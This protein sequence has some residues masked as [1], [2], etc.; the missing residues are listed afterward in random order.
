MVISEA[1]TA[2]LR[3][4]TSCMHFDYSQKVTKDTKRR[5]R[6]EVFDRAAELQASNEM[7]A[8]NI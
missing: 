5:N 3:R 7:V 1:F 2:L 6:K 4:S 8:A